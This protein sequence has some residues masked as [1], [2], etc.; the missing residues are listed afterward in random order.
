MN[1]MARCASISIHRQGHNTVSELIEALHS[2]P[3]DTGVVD[4]T[5]DYVDRPARIR[6][7]DVVEHGI[8]DLEE[9]AVVFKVST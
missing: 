2:P 4:T 3:P 6:H 5:H 8:I 9:Q 7:I 1:G